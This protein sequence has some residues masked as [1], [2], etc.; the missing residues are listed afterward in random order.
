M[1]WPALPLPRNVRVL[2]CAALLPFGAGRALEGGHYPGRTFGF[3]EGLT[4]TSV[5]TMA[6]GEDGL[7]YAGTEGGLFR[8][9]G[10]RFEALALPANHQFIT[11]LLP[12]HGGRLWVGTRNGLGFLDPA[13]AFHA[14]P[15]LLAQRIEYLGFDARGVPS[16]QPIRMARSIGTSPRKGRPMRKAA[17]FTPP[18][19]KIAVS[20]WQLGQWKLD[21]F[22]TMPRMGTFTVWNRPMA[23]RASRKA[24]SWGVLTTMAPSTLAFW[25]SEIWVSPVPGGRSMKR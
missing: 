23:L 2:L 21:M 15:G 18:C 17:A 20:V 16:S 14:E 6:Q 22:S 7:I 9:D 25:M 11:T 1:P 3:A 4:N 12:E 10:R 24:T 13:G 5:I 19:P 8:F